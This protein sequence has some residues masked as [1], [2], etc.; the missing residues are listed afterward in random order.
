MASIT[1]NKAEL[2][3][4]RSVFTTTE[5]RLKLSGPTETGESEFLCEA[6]L[7]ISILDIKRIRSSFKESKVE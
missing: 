3:S 5:I 4:I 6:S 7:A 2:G 1:L